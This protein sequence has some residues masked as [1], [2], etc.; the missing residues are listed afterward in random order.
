MLYCPSCG[1]ASFSEMEQLRYVCTDCRFEIYRNVAA[2]V[3]VI[4]RCHE[5]IL[6]TVRAD[7]PG[8]GMLD[9]PGGFVDPGES[10][11]A[12]ARREIREELN[13]ELPGLVYVFSE[14]N[15]YPFRGVTYHTLDAIFETRLHESPV[16]TASD[17]VAGVAWLSIEDLDLDRIALRSIKN[18]IARLKGGRVLP[19]GGR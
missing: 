4:I 11:E 15:V 14:P 10:L 5:N 16:M 18:G 8:K 12:A 9:L 2:A 13:I 19:V 1:K 6:F 3:G 17:E 7:D